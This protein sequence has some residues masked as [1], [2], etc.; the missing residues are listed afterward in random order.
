MNRGVQQAASIR[1]FRDSGSEYLGV[2]RGFSGSD[3]GS[4]LFGSLLLRIRAASWPGRRLIEI[5]LR[6]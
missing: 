6:G 4:V 3:P 2:D 5:P 1:K